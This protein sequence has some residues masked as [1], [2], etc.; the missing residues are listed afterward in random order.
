M[1][2]ANLL[3]KL[4]SHLT[5]TFASV[6]EW[7]DQPAALREYRPADLGWT[8]NEVLAHIGLTNH[9]LLILVEKGTAK[10]LANTQGGELAT[11]LAT[12]K[13][14][15]KKLGAIGV[16]HAFAWVRPAHT[17]SRTSTT[18]HCP[19]FASSYATS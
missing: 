2:I 13:F 15:R 8:T 11:E 1:V 3:E 10:A 12:Y 14:P 19:P 5:T 17:W 4:R 7:F 6:D 18:C 9:Y 16:L